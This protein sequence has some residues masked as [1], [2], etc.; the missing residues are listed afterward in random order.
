[1]PQSLKSVAFPLAITVVHLYLFCLPY[2]VPRTPSLSP[3]GKVLLTVCFLHPDSE[4]SL[5]NSRDQPD[6]KEPELTA[7]ALGP[8]SPG[9]NPRFT[10]G[11]ILS[12]S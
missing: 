4:A 3:A 10:M 12:P 6:R 9:P 8:H 2:T 1:M 5:V 11:R 7:Q